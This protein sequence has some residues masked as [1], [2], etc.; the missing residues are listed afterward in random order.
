MNE[1]LTQAKAHFMQGDALAR[2]GKLGLAAQ[3]FRQTLALHPSY[4]DAHTALGLVLLIGGQK[5]GNAEFIAQAV[6]SLEQALLLRPNHVDTRLHLCKAFLLLSR[7]QKAVAEGQKITALKPELAEGWSLLGQAYAKQPDYA[8]AVTCYRKSLDLRPQDAPDHLALALILERTNH[9]DEARGIIE[10]GRTIAPLDV[11]FLLP[12][13]RIERRQGNV[14]VAKA[15]LEEILR[16]G[17]PPL[18]RNSACHELAKALDA[19]GMYDEA[20][21]YYK[22]AQDAASQTAEAQRVD[23]KTFDALMPVQHR[24][25]SKERMDTHLPPSAPTAQESPIFLVGFPR[26]G[27]TLVEQILSSH[28]R[29]TGTQEEEI[30]FRMMKSLPK[31]LGRPQPYPA[32][33]DTVSPEEASRLREFYFT[34]AARATG[35]VAGQGRTLDK[36]PINILYL[37]LIYWLF[38]KARVLVLLRDPRDV[39]LS[40]FMQLFTNNV[41]MNHFFTLEST[42]QFYAL[43]MDMYR[44]YR[45][46]LPLDMLEIRYEDIVANMEGNTRKILEFVG[47]G[48]DDSVLEYYKEDKNRHVSTPSYEGVMRPI[49]TS[50]VQRWKHYEKHLAPVMGVLKPYVDAFGYS[51]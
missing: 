23:T 46:V 43:T 39:T 22:E 14:A 27:T 6:K 42:V 20:F 11:Q 17:A 28:P 40:C 16:R 13:A 26:S 31:L 29:I 24:W 1:V 47:E 35:V 49:Y 2:Q 9:L 33:L 50:S 41:A 38:P 18:I 37:G 44:H 10:Q 48:W 25:F 15:H 8:E 3:E 30:F 45:N 5:S 19:E 4:A 34:Q 32:V 36:Q 51:D 21:R 12:L 7:P